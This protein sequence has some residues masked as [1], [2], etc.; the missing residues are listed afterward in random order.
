MI[1]KLLL[2]SLISKY[3]LG[4]NES[5]KW[6]IK[7][8]ALSIGFM[9]PGD[10]IIGEVV[11][12]DFQLEDVELAIFNTNK[13]KNLTAITNG[14][15]LL[16]L[17]K[18]NKLATKLKISDASF[19]LE[20]ALSDPLLI[21][22][23]KKVKEYDY[24]IIMT[25]DPEEITHLIKARSAL[26]DSSLLRIGTDR[27]LD[28]NSI[29]NF[30]FGEGDSYSDKIVYQKTGEINS[31]LSSGIPF[32]SNAFKNILNANKD[33][34]VGYIRLFSGGLLNLSFEKETIK[35][36]YYMVRKEDLPF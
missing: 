32:D 3:Y 29:V 12:S 36:N 16:E 27:D 35:S 7:D 17:I 8:N 2:Q 14:E 25:L 1:Q 33:A 10:D 9:S 13:L 30:T 11:C 26:S 31:E 19:N 23:P 20:F 34:D 28:N 15:L 6:V 4:I 5:V 21:R 18:E 24:E 22:T